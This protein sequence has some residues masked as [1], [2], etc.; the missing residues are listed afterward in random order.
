MNF[1]KKII[2]RTFLRDSFASS[3]K[4]FED[5]GFSRSIYSSQ[6]CWWGSWR[7]WTTSLISYTQKWRKNWM[8]RTLWHCPKIASPFWRIQAIFWRI[9]GQK[10]APPPPIVFRAKLKAAKAKKTS[11]GEGGGEVVGRKHGLKDADLR[12][13]YAG[14]RHLYAPDKCLF[15]VV[16]TKKGRRKFV[17]FFSAKKRGLGVL[18]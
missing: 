5:L 4:L 14:V 18:F 2:K 7:C 1:W 8:N 16:E 13:F 9:P 10:G 6:S 17:Y 12:F 11:A 3:H 15:G